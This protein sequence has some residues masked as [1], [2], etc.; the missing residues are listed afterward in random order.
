MAVCFVGNTTAIQE[1]FKRVAEQSLGQKAEGVGIGPAMAL[2]FKGNLPWLYLT[3]V[4]IVP[5]RDSKVISS[6]WKKKR[7][8][9]SRACSV[10]RPSSTGTR[11]TRDNWY[12]EAKIKRCH[13]FKLHN[14]AFLQGR[15]K[16]DAAPS[17]Y[18]KA[19]S[20][21]G[22]GMDEMEFTEAESNMNDLVSEYQQYQDATA[23]EG[24]E[25]E[26]DDEM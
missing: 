11:P 3:T 5:R 15:E 26:E 18:T 1:M 24:E 14:G 4:T 23:E 12:S 25:E 17:R 20:C 8:L 6:R 16:K 22:E 2:R 10:A 7:A 9:G 21:R 13:A 19:L